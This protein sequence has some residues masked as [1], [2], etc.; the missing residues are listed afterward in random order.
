MTKTKK[1]YSKSTLKSF[2]ESKK[3]ELKDLLIATYED[4]ESNDSQ[5]LEINAQLDLLLTIEKIC[6]ERKRW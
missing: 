3:E 2:I 4:I 5:I 6:I 1:V